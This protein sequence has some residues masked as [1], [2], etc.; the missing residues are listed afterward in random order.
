MNRTLALL[1]LITAASLTACGSRSS[2]IRTALIDITGESRSVPVYHESDWFKMFPIAEHRQALSIG[3]LL[4]VADVGQ[5][6][7]LP[8]N[9]DVTTATG[10]AVVQSYRLVGEA[11]VP[12][13]WN[14]VTAVRDALET[15]QA[16]AL[17]A[18]ILA[19]EIAALMREAR[20]ASG[21]ARASLVQTLGQRRQELTEAEQALSEARDHLREAANTPGIVI[22]RWSTTESAGFSIDAGSAARG[23]LDVSGNRSGFV[24]LGGLRVVSLVFGEDFWWLLNNLRDHEKKHIETIGITTNLLQARDVAYT[25]DASFGYGLRVAVD[26]ESRASDRALAARVTGYWSFLGQYTNSGNLPRIQWKREPFCM[27]CGLDLPG[28]AESHEQALQQYFGVEHQPIDPASYSGW[29]TVAATVTY[30]RD[31]PLTFQWAKH[32]NKYAEERTMW[33]ASS[34]PFCSKHEGPAVVPAP[35]VASPDTDE[36]SEEGH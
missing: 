30:L 11:D 1:I 3:G 8:G 20:D 19:A 32:A 28:L 2:P 10:I 33:P 29:R 6:F 13:D 7:N 31:V 25:S 24:V 16:R 15:A 5:E 36:E 4:N 9:R 22:A 35:G 14:Q 23:G 12:E 21:R 17:D 34:C 18:S 26:L 27:V